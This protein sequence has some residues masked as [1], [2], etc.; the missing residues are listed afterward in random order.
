MVATIT[1]VFVLLI[2]YSLWTEAVFLGIGKKNSLADRC[3]N[4]TVSLIISSSG[5]HISKMYVVVSLVSLFPWG[6][7]GDRRFFLLPFFCYFLCPTL[8]LFRCLAVRGRGD[9]GAL[10]GST[11]SIWDR[12]WSRTGKQ[13]TVCYL[14]LPMLPLPCSTMFD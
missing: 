7:P 11:K 12:K 3:V 8:F 10:L 6:G 13:C 5:P 2:R 14:R 4:W 1:S 9:Q